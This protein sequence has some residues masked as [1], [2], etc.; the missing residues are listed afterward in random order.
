MKLMNH[1]II[2]YQIGRELKDHLVQPFL[3]KSRSR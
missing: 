1:R 3:G 2:E